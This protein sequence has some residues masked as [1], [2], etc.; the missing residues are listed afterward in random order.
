MR[1]Y[2]RIRKK[3]STQCGNASVVVQKASEHQLLVRYRNPNELLHVLLDVAH[4]G[5]V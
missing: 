4:S 1:M 2:I 3:S 5:L